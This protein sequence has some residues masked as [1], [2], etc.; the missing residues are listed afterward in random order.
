MYMQENF[1]NQHIELPFFV[2]NL[3]DF[4]DGL[5]EKEGSL[6]AYTKKKKGEE[7]R[8]RGSQLQLLLSKDN[9]SGC[10]ERENILRR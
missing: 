8:P 5:H 4:V 2:I 3:V 7:G 6:K 1:Y 9:S 10:L